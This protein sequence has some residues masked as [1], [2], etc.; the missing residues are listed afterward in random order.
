MI[1]MLC[2]H[3]TYRPPSSSN[4]FWEHLNIAVN[5]ASETSNHITITGDIN[6]DMLN[7]AHRNPLKDVMTKY[8]F[9]NIITEPTRVGHS[10]CTM[11]DPILL[12]DTICSKSSYV[13]DVDRTISDH[14]AAVC[15]LQVPVKLCTTF[16]MN[17]WL[18]KSLTN[19]FQT[20]TGF[21]FLETAPI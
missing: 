12:T 9:L 15:H 10:S 4:S 20:S 16:K 2:L 11:L 7:L 18:Y 8:G 17:V 13:I 3:V 14:N 6:V 1:L 5:K 19:L 21:I